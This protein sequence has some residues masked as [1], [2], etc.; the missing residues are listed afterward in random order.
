MAAAETT[1]GATT[2]VTSLLPGVHEAAG[3]RFR[4][5]DAMPAWPRHYGDPAGEYRA[6]VEGGA[7]LDR[8]HRA[9]WRVGGRDP[10]RMLNGI[11]TNTRSEERRG[12]TECRA[13]C[14]SRWAPCP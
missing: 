1:S 6:A 11:V 9:R 7:M 8:T 14:R 4:E 2:E 12:G 13:L 5:G 3:A 10:A